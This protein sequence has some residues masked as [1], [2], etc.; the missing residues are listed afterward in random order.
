MQPSYIRLLS[1]AFRSSC[2]EEV[3]EH[4]VEVTATML[5]PQS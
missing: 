4:K 2:H 1:N 5:L 3:R